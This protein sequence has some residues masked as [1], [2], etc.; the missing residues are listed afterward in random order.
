LALWAFLAG[1]VELGE[2][3]CTELGLVALEI[4]ELVPV[5]AE[6]EP[7]GIVPD[8]PPHA[9]SPVPA[10]AKAQAKAARRPKISILRITFLC[11]RFPLPRQ[12]RRFLAEAAPAVS[13]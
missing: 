5:R 9:V 10:S 1:A 2:L 3:D 12:R 7:L 6:A 11:R 4:V 13:W 8:E